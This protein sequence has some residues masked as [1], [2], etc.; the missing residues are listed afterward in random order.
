MYGLLPKL[1]HDVKMQP[2]MTSKLML[3]IVMF[4]VYASIQ[5]KDKVLTALPGS[6]VMGCPKNCLAVTINELK[7]SRLALALLKIANAQL[8]R[9]L[10]ISKRT[11]CNTFVFTQKQHNTK[12]P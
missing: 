12:F 8:I 4:H 10:L 6:H 7:T 2:T 1:N 9:G 11:H 5:V 3:K